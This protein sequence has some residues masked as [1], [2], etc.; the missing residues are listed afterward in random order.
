M[1]V[2]LTLNTVPVSRELDTDAALSLINM[3]TY[4]KIAQSSQL[5]LQKSDI[6]LRTY[7]GE[8]INISGSAEVKVYTQRKTKVF[9]L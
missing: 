8:C 3:E 2:E 7:T 5:P 4:H 1:T 6:M 9:R